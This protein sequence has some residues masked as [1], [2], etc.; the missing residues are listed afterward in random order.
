MIHPELVS[1][2]AQLGRSEILEHF[3]FFYSSIGPFLSRDRQGA[4]RRSICETA[5]VVATG[6]IPEQDCGFLHAHGVAAVF[7]PGTKL[8]IA[9]GDILKKLNG[10]S[11][12]R[13]IHPQLV[14][15]LARLGRSGILEHF[16]FFCSSIG[17][18]PSRDRQGAGR[19][20]IC[21]TALVVASGVIPEHDYAFLDAYGVAAIFGPGTKFPIAPG[22]ILKTLNGARR[23][24]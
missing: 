2:L 22:D 5:V 17:P 12:G 10:G 11:A 6:V 20:S 1:K 3:S 24:A 13:M 23:A 4:G 21:E 9:A 14:S 8:P 7:E 16:S 18:L 15:E 19:H